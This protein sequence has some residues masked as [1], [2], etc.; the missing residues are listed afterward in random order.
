[1]VDV[2]QEHPPFLEGFRM[3][4]TVI[5]MMCP[6]LRCRKLLSVPSR[7]RGKNVRCAKC[8]AYVKVP[9]AKQPA[10]TEPPQENMV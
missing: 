3:G 9:G 6:N 8:G 2:K 1:M 7:L 10:E 4:K 5:K